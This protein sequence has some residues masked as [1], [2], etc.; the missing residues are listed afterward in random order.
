M[1]SASDLRRRR[2]LD[3][4]S[5]PAPARLDF[6]CRICY[7]LLPTNDIARIVPVRGNAMLR[8]LPVM[9]V[10][11]VL[12]LA[13][14]VPAKAVL[15]TVNFNAAGISSGTFTFDS[16][17]VDPGNPVGDVNGSTDLASSISI[18][19]TFGQTWTSANAGVNYLAFDSSGNLTEWI[20]GGDV[21]GINN[22]GV[23]FVADFRV[24]VLSGGS[25]GEAQSA[26]GLYILNLNTV[27]WSFSPQ[28]PYDGG[29]A[30]EPASWLLL[31]GALVGLVGVRRRAR[32]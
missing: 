15:I 7:I 22:V 2:I 26:S 32:K 3:A 23:P 6:T 18:T 10:L 8:A 4:L 27:T 25:I 1:R 16:S 12:S 5:G 24:N 21:D 11:A 20:L 31:G 13:H 14:A 30:P 19:D 9:L 17:I 29:A 28:P